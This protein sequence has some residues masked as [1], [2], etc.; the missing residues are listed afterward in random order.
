MLSR[1]HFLFGAAVAA[2]AGCSAQGKE[3]S[4]PT[5][6]RSAM[7]TIEEFSP[8]G[9]S[10]GR[11]QVAT[12]V[13]TDAEWRKQLT[14]DSYEITRRSETERPGSGKYDNNHAAGIY[15]CICCDTA[16]Y[17]SATKF[18]SGTGWPSFWQPISKLNIVETKDNSLLMQR[19][20]VSC[21]RCDAH[22]GHVFD[23]GPQPTGLRYCM[24]SV[25]LNFVS[26]A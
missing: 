7:V 2:C 26:R 10:L 3:Q 13:K 5:P 9:K 12:I 18:D 14:R 21:A 15:R 16:L 23:D 17:D 8:A 4:E 22:L 19:V 25:A 1:R 24:N 6:K 20:A 11:S